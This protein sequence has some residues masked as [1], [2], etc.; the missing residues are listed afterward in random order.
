MADWS[1]SLQRLRDVCGRSGPS[2][3]RSPELPSHASSSLLSIVSDTR[4]SQQ[5]LS[6]FELKS[7]LNSTIPLQMGTATESFDSRI[8]YLNRLVSD[9]SI[10]SN[11]IVAPLK[12]FESNSPIGQLENLNRVCDASSVTLRNTDNNI[13]SS[14]LKQWEAANAS[15]KQRDERSLHV[16]SNSTLES[17]SNSVNSPKLQTVNNSEDDDFKSDASWDTNSRQHDGTDDQIYSEMIGRSNITTPSSYSGREISSLTPLD[18]TLEGIAYATI[19]RNNDKDGFKRSLETIMM[20][21][22]LEILNNERS[23]IFK[24]NEQLLGIRTYLRWQHWA[25]EQKTRRVYRAASTRAAREAAILSERIIR[26]AVSALRNANTMRVGEK[27]YNLWFWY[28]K[29]STRKLRRFDNL[30]LMNSF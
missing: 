17:A 30:N 8:N 20:N 18:T 23:E 9:V 16:G 6:E 5:N 15:L 25:Q 24:L 27:Y 21:E 28:S 11:E 2:L 4:V 19:N 29:K 12:T 3:L 26:T 22:P 13:S 7:Q 10:N 14:E 1:Q